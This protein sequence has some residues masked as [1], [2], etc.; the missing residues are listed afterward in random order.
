MFCEGCD[1]KRR[2]EVEPEEEG[3]RKHRRREAAGLGIN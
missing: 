3:P 2:N 1:A